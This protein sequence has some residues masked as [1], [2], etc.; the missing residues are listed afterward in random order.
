M[1]GYRGEAVLPKPIAAGTKERRWAL[2]FG[3][4]NLHSTGGA[5]GSQQPGNAGGLAGWTGLR[6]E[7][8]FGTTG[9]GRI[10]SYP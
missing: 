4:V 2:V 8:A 5:T 10:R 1:G 6:L 7:L 3:S 9:R